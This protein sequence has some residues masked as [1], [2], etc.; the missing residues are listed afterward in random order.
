MVLEKQM[1]PPITYKVIS[2]QL[3]LTFYSEKDYIYLWKIFQTTEHLPES[4]LWSKFTPTPDSLVNKS[5][6]SYIFTGLDLCFMLVHNSMIRKKEK[7]SQ[8]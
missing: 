1:L 4:G 6:T 7:K 5:K 3:S 8:I 2:K